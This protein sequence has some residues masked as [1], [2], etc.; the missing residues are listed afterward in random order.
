MQPAYLQ[1]KTFIQQHISSGEWRPSDPVPSEATLMQQF[2]ISQGLAG[3]SA[4]L[5]WQAAAIVG[6]LGGG[7]LADRWMQRSERGRGF[8]GRGADTGA[9]VQTEARVV[10]PHQAR[11][12][13]RSGQSA[14]AG[15]DQRSQGRPAA[16]S[17]GDLHG[18]R[19]FRVH[20]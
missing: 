10:N 5:Y 17:C 15:G 16:E 20:R 4:T 1:V 19:L 8:F 2:G 3:V 13:R 14:R 9:G 18:V 7:F 6:A 11:R 12:F